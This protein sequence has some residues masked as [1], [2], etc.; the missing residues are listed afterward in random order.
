MV[1]SAEFQ[2]DAVFLFRA[3]S[4]VDVNYFPEPVEYRFALERFGPCEVFSYPI[5]IVGVTRGQS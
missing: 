5:S 4:T 1:P 2:F 3:S